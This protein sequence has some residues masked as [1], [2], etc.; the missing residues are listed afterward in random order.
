LDLLRELAKLHNIIQYPEEAFIF[1]ASSGSM[2]ILENQLLTHQR[3]IFFALNDATPDYPLIKYRLDELKFFA[4]A[5]QQSGIVGEKYDKC[6]DELRKKMAEIC[7]NIT[8]AFNEKFSKDGM[9]VDEEIKKYKYMQQVEELMKTH[10]REGLKPTHQLNLHFIELS[11][12]IK[13]KLCKCNRDEIFTQNMELNRLKRISNIFEDTLIFYQQSCEYLRTLIENSITAL[14]DLIYKDEYEKLACEINQITRFKD[15]FQSHEWPKG[16]EKNFQNIKESLKSALNM[17]KELIVALDNKIVLITDDDISKLDQLFARLDFAM[18]S[19]EG[20]KLGEELANI[21]NFWTQKIVTIFK[22]LTEEVKENFNKQR[23]EERFVRIESIVKCIISI[24]KISSIKPRISLEFSALKNAIR[25]QLTEIKSK[26]DLLL[27]QIFATNTIYQSGE[28][29]NYLRCLVSTKWV[30]ELQ[31]I[32]YHEIM[33]NITQSIASSFKSFEEQTVDIESHEYIGILSQSLHKKIEYEMPDLKAH[34]PE[35]VSII[36]QAEGS[37]FEKVNKEILS[38]H[39]KTGLNNSDPKSLKLKTCIKAINFLDACSTISALKAKS[40]EQK[41]ILISSIK[42][43]YITSILAELESLNDS[44][45]DS[46]EH[47]DKIVSEVAKF[48]RSFNEII[49]IENS[50]PVIFSLFPNHKKII[51]CWKIR[52]SEQFDRFGTEMEQLLVR[53]NLP[54]L[55]NK[56]LIAKSLRMLD[57]Y[58]TAQKSY[59]ELGNQYNG[60]LASEIDQIK[61]QLEKNLQEF[62]YRLAADNFEDLESLGIKEVLYQ[63]KCK[64]SLWELKELTRNSIVKFLALIPEE[65]DSICKNLKNIENF[66]K[67]VGKYN[68]EETTREM[69][70]SDIRMILSEKVKWFAEGING[71]IHAHKFTEA[72][73]ELCK[74][75]VI[76]QLFEKYL[77]SEAITLIEQLMT[78]KNEFVTK[79]LV[80]DFSNVDKLP[81]VGDALRQLLN[82]LHEAKE[83]NA[84]NIYDQAY[85]DI[86]VKILSNF[87]DRLEKISQTPQTLQKHL[88]KLKQALNALPLVLQRKLN[89]DIEDVLQKFTKYT[90][91]S[92]IDEPFHKDRSKCIDLCDEGHPPLLEKIDLRFRLIGDEGAR[93]L[94]RNKSWINLTTLSLQVNNIGDEGT[95]ALSENTYWIN[96][97][98]LDLSNNII[99]EEGARKLSENKFWT[100]LQVLMLNV[101]SIGDRGARALSE[102][103]SW[104]HLSTLNLS[105]NN[106]GD[107]GARA[108]GENKSWSNLQSLGLDNNK[109]C[110]EGVR[111]LSTKSSWTN[112]KGLNL[113]YNNI[114]DEGARALSENESWVKISTLDLDKDNIG[115][116][117]ARA[118]SQNK[119]WSKLAQL[120]LRF[121]IFGDEGA[122]ELTQ[123]QKIFSHF[124]FCY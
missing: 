50:Y 44:I 47:K 42:K 70:F 105:C 87:G 26:I 55:K 85:R 121:N 21:N 2:V 102:N 16:I 113:S 90:E 91:E 9:S 56:I 71:L 27:S 86:Q 69:I 22:N 1:K 35:I 34:F 6:V 37:F 30:G 54:A 38:V 99:G 84:C 8:F 109:I 112:L 39:E 11:Q 81:Y 89:E 4:D 107:E 94:S 119:T 59:Q 76:K 3:E 41:E 10:L 97:N 114:G 93:A 83:K 36:S 82:R 20:T 25:D 95:R 65:G 29:V 100:N 17:P 5:L 45:I 32:D 49:D 106:I 64:N 51:N 53:R 66:F 101:N 96:L 52:L 122:R 77:S 33:R 57:L 98:W 19:F 68:Q 88:P 18:T 62:E 78:T 72:E 61:I 58:L 118:L 123:R 67:Y 120:N 75:N 111:E 63:N 28:L 31:L 43:G 15:Q 108:L 7:D 12:N 46:F 24:H 23:I 103:N 79:E 117:G 124:K 48:I 104:T 116:E 115:D 80:E 13:E 60:K 14:K 74:I 110:A 40:V 92:L 73:N